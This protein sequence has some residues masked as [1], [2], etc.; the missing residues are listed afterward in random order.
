MPFTARDVI[1]GA[2]LTLQDANHT[3]WTLD[4]LRKYLNDG[5][6]A[7]ATY[8]PTA[9]TDIVILELV[10]GT[11]QELGANQK[12]VSVKRNITS[13]VGVTPIVAG[14]VATTIDGAVLDTQ[15]PNWHDT[16][17]VPFSATVSHVVYDERAPREFYVFPGNDGNGRLECSIATLPTDIAAPS[18]IADLDQYTAVVEL[19]SEY[20]NPLRD[21]VLS[22]AFSKDLAM[23]GSAQR[24][25]MHQG[26]FAQALGITAQ[27]E[28]SLSP[29]NEREQQ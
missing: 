24:A 28:T 6:R 3:R 14:K 15:I 19:P 25:V 17:T 22:R 1:S 16:A 20:L 9:V 11:R 2:Q 27:M 4:E 18:N 29:N 21:Y 7:I 23:P 10:A 5:V 12:L 26:Q 8:K 13:G